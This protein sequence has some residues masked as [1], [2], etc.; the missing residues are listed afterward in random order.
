MLEK[1]ISETYYYNPNDY[2]E[3]GRRKCDGMTFR[4]RII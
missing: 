4:G 3:K 2:D 1:E